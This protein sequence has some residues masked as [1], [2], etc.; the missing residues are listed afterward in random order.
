LNDVIES[1]QGFLSG[2]HGQIDPE[3]LADAY[4][5]R[6]V[7]VQQSKGMIRTRNPF[8]KVLSLQSGRFQGAAIYRLKDEDRLVCVIGGSVYVYNLSTGSS[9]SFADKFNPE[10]SCFFCQADRYFIIQDG[11]VGSSHEDANWP[12][13]LHED[14]LID[15]SDSSSSFYV[16]NP[17]RRLPKGGPMAYGHGRLFVAVNYIPTVGDGDVVAYSEN[18]GRTSFLAGDL[19]KAGTPSDVL[20]FTDTVY[21]N[22]GGAIKLPEELGTITAMG[23]QRSINQSAI[24]SGPLIV[25]AE[26]GASAFGINAPRT[27]WGALDF[28]QVLFSTGG[29]Q[30][31]WS[32]EPVNSDLFFRGADGIRTLRFT[33]TAS[34]S[35]SGLLSNDPISDEVREFTD[36]DGA[37]LREL[38][39]A[40][41][42]NR[43]LTTTN[44]ETAETGETVFRGLVSLDTSPASALGKAS[45]ALYD[46]VWTG[47][48]FAQVLSGSPVGSGILY[49]VVKDGSDNVLLRLADSPGQDY[50]ETDIQ[51]R[52]YLR[53]FPFQSAFIRKRFKHL[54][55]WL[56]DLVGDVSL[57]AYLNGDSGY[58]VPVTDETAFTIS[59]GSG[60]LGPVRLGSSVYDNVCS[61]TTRRPLNTGCLLQFCLAWSGILRL[62][63]GKLVAVPL[64]DDD[65]TDTGVLDGQ[66]LDGSVPDNA[67]DLDDFD[68]EVSL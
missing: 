54:D 21:F 53:A 2:M 58:W 3:L 49:A 63:R 43:A 62:T 37:C 56:S 32:L 64:T 34:A 9:V 27:N 66:S 29:T 18:E 30:S 48:Q 25:F 59:E 20:K 22:A 19:I 68:Y 15:Q 24:G 61:P 33:A 4:Y 26:H 50:P 46:G 40:F 45:S 41:S 12:V 14:Q 17:G 65:R 39:L 44:P 60:S 11:Y 1:F 5:A 28:S 10:A 36:L 57:R 67:V 47:Y 38:S 23:F 42:S 8:S 31:P 6:G 35:S 16:S 55:L 7:N 52:L 51:S 13:I